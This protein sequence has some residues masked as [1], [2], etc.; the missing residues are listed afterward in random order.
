MSGWREHHLFVVKSL[1]RIQ[2]DL[3][4][5]KSDIKCDIKSVQS[6]VGEIKQS[7]HSLDKDLNAVKIKS[8]LFGALAGFFS[9]LIK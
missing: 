5:F 2:A 7:M 3:A 9:G 4:E 1:E 6:D 8:T